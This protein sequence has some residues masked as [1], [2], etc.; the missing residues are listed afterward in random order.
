MNDTFLR[1]V[2]IIVTYDFAAKKHREAN[3]N[4]QS[5]QMYSRERIQADFN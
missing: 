3:T 5:D 4:V 1:V 2:F